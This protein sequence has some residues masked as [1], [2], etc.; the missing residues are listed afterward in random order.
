M[1][2]FYLDHDS[3]L[4]SQ[5]MCNK[6]VVKQVLESAQLLCTSHHVC[7]DTELP[8]FLYKKTHINHPCT[9]WVRECSANYAW[10]AYHAI[11]LCQEYTYRY[12]KIHKSQPIIEWCLDNFPDVPIGFGTPPAQAMPD[13]Y[14]DS[15][16]VKAYRN[17]YTQHKRFV[18]DMKWTKRN[19]P[20]WW[21]YENK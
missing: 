1:N 11:S 2:I 6:H 7:C 13:E 20:Y 19:P 8:D 9:K 15:D 16:P 17:Y 3:K 12:G 4:A 10:L 5:A 18:M 14:K 21:P